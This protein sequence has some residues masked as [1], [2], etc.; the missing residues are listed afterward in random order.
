M[1]ANQR[2]A[3][4]IECRIGDM[5]QLP[6]YH[7]LLL[8]F[9]QRGQIGDRKLHVLRSG[10]DLVRNAVLYLHARTQDFMTLQ[11][12]VEAGFQGGDVER[13]VHPHARCN[14]IGRIAGMHLLQ[15]P[16]PLLRMR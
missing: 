10:D 8:F 2:T 3:R 7:T 5:L 6:L 9:Y 11:Y 13:P 4:Q 12:A 1:C 16:E 15:E 14:H